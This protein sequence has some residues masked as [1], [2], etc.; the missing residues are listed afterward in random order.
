MRILFVH[1]E[2]KNN[3][4]I[5]QFELSEFKTLRTGGTLQLTEI[6]HRLATINGNPS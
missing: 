5:Q 4:L 2:N 6:R 3:D 1:K